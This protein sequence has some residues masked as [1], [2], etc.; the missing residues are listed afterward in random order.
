MRIENVLQNYDEFST[1]KALKSV[2]MNNP[3]EL[4]DFKETHFVSDEDI[5]AMQGI[6][7]AAERTTQDYRSVYNDIRDWLRREKAGKDKENSSIDWDD[8]VFEV[9][10]LKS[11][12]I[13]LDYNL[14]LIFEKNQKVKDKETLVEEVRRLIRSST[15]NRA[16]ESLVVDFINQTDLDKIQDKVN[17][18]I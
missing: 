8:I 10:L 2:D 4:N 7:I 9:D 13:N 16:K 11:Q 18:L 15:G 3:E 1:L 12:E 6:K 5:V 17:I 14:E